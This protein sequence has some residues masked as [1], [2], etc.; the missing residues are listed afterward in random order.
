MAQ[1]ITLSKSAAPYMGWS[2]LWSLSPHQ[3][4]GQ[5][6]HVQALCAARIKHPSMVPDTRQGCSTTRSTVKLTAVIRISELSNAYLSC[7]L[8]YESSKLA[9]ENIHIIHI[10]HSVVTYLHPNST[11]SAH[12]MKQGEVIR[13]LSLSI[14]TTYIFLWIFKGFE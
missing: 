12:S 10:F 8:F 4:G 7:Y 5:R 3:W 13:T 2:N 11:W 6:G 1:R 14:V 9:G